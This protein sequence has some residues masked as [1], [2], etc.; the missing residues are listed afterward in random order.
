[1][2]K[3]M[4]IIMSLSV[5][6][7]AMVAQDQLTDNEKKQLHMK[8]TFIKAGF[9]CGTLHKDIS[10][11]DIEKGMKEFEYAFNIET[12]DK[13]EIYELSFL[14]GYAAGQAFIN[15]VALAEI[16]GKNISTKKMDKIINGTTE[17]DLDIIF[18]AF[19]DCSEKV[20]PFI[21]A[22]PFAP[23]KRIDIFQNIVGQCVAQK[24]LRKVL[25]KDKK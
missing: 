1:M 10:Q 23:E 8:L 13:D 7:T 11:K 6:C 24:L 5:L 25:E 2:K 15:N 17:E 3:I 20:M 22:T 4:M 14:V 12:Y 19:S 9:I 16:D 21:Q 18:K